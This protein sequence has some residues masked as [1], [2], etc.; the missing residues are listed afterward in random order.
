MVR[1]H[2]RHDF[3]SF[4]FVEV[5]FILPTVVVL[6]YSWDLKKA[7]TVLLLDGLLYSCQWDPVGWWC[8]WV[9]LYSCWF[10]NCF[11]N[12]CGKGVDVSTINFGF[13]YISFYFC[14]FHVTYIAD[15]LFCACTFRIDIY[16]WW[17]DPFII[18]LQPSLSLVIFISL[19]TFIRYWNNHYCF[20]L[21]FSSCIFFHLF[22]LSTYIM[23]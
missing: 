13:V 11:I 1:Q 2:T 18:M 8:Y 23:K 17:I 20:L 12:C 15:L 6:V 3:N 16:S 22:T 7:C 5:Y 9:L 21:I 10:S 14:L 4:K 19:D